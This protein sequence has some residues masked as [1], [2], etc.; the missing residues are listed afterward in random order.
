MGLLLVQFDEGGMPLPHAT[1]SWS[2]TAPPGPRTWPIR[3][4]LT[5]PTDSRTWLVAW[6]DEDEDGRVDPGERISSPQAPQPMLAAGVDPK[7][8]AATEVHLRLDRAATGPVGV[9]GYGAWGRWVATID[10][11][12]DTVQTR[13]ARLLLVGYKPEHVTSEGY[14]TREGRPMLQWTSPDKQRQWPQVVEFEVPDGATPI[15][16]AILDRNGDGH[17]SPGDRLG[18]TGTPVSDTPP[19]GG[20]RIVIDQELPG[21]EAILPDVPRPAGCGG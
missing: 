4:V 1:P 10:G 3:E 6:I 7:A 18:S 14:P 8:A 9:K 15:L 13:D 21:T 2:W 19:V 16:F 17:M 12:A 11:D 20:Y 5:V